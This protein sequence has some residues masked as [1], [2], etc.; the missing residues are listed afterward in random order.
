MIFDERLCCH[1]RD[2]LDTDEV[3]REQNQAI[4]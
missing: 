3:Q 1:P 4:F 2:A